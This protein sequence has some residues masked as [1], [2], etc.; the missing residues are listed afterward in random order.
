MI[1]F[2]LMNLVIYEKQLIMIFIY[3]LTMLIFNIKL[4]LKAKTKIVLTLLVHGQQFNLKN[5]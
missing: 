3:K 4:V 5:Y 1:F 2:Q